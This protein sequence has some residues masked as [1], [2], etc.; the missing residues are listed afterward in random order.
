MKK[1][2]V[3]AIFILVIIV[4]VGAFVSSNRNPTPL[5]HVNADSIHIDNHRP[6]AG[7]SGLGHD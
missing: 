2:T 1:N 3:V 5:A 4:A 7:P 6:T